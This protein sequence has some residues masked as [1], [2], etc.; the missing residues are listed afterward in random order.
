[1]SAATPFILRRWQKGDEIALVKYANNYNVWR[2]VRD[3]FPYP[4]TPKDAEGWIQLCQGE[5]KPTVF[6]IE[7]A[8]EAVGGAGIVPQKDV[9]RK[10]AEIGYW[11][12]EPFWGKGIASA[13]ARQMAE[14]AFREFDVYRLYA[15]VFE[16]N[17]PSMKVLEKAGFT[18]E[19]VAKK[20]I[21]KENQ[22]YDEY[23]Y[24]RFRDSLPL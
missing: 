4:Y 17:V 12:G 11:L 16:Y 8:G 14:Y 1:M 19:A 20:A 23:I 9:F 24:V 21:C 6:A 3:S 18:L 2:N 5:D 15:G 22:L 10:N 13:V 7:I